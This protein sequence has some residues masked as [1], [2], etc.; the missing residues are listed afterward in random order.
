[1]IAKGHIKGNSE[2]KLIISVNVRLRMTGRYAL[3]S[4]SLRVSG[5]EE[6]LN[7]YD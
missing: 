7:L 3:C 2:K 6:R 1:M 4:V 5:V